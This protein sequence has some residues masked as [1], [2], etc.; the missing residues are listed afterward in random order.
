MLQQY[1]LW[2]VLACAVLAVL[3]GALS[4]RWVL[5]Q[6]PGNARM[7]E[8]A[9]AIQEGAKAYLNRQYTTIGGV[10]VVLFLIIGFALDWGTAD[11][12]RGGR[13]PV[14]RYRL[15]RHER[16]GP[17]QCAHRRS[18]PKRARCGTEC[19]VPRRRHHR[20]AGGWPGPARRHRV[21]P[22][23]A[24]PGLRD[25]ARAARA[26][27]PGLRLVADLDLRAPG[28]RHLHQ[29]RRR[30]RGPGRQ[31]GSRHSG[32]RP[33]QPG[34]DRGQRGRQRRRLR[35]HGSRPVRNLC[36]DPDRHH[37][38]GRRHGRT[39]GQQWRAVPA[40]AGWRLHRGLD[41]RHVLREGA[42]APRS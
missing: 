11:R 36:G 9:A 18:C 30:R 34:G 21:L 25:H 2:I 3:Y 24:L 22:R 23:A 20:H 13:H 4:V 10:G 16:F 8:I 7:Q 1:G 29:G 40:A 32:R 19:G 12:L 17:R 15:Y 6:S 26:G 42:A 33:A 28:R 39:D 14:R 5:A 38:A 35:R 27:R 37:A 41:H 31:G